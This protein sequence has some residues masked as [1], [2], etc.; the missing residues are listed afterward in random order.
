MSGI[1][2]V[3]LIILEN[4][5]SNGIQSFVEQFQNYT[6]QLFKS[7]IPGKCYIFMVEAGKMKA[8]AI[9]KGIVYKFLIQ[10]KGLIIKI[11]KIEIYTEKL[12]NR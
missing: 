8:K 5:K 11:E 6:R 10:K 12:N 9:E 3:L 4:G 2:L 7:V 1:L